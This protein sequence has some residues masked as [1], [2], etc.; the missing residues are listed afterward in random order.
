MYAVENIVRKGEKPGKHCPIKLLNS[1]L[2]GLKVVIVWFT[3]NAFAKS[4]HPCLHVKGER[5][6]KSH[7]TH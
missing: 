4:I 2:L 7:T 5:Q 3:I 6:C 1:F